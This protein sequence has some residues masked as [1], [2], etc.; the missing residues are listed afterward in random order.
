[1]Q[2]CEW[3]TQ[4]GN[5][6]DLSASFSRTVVTQEWYRMLLLNCHE[7]DYEARINFVAINPGGQHLSLSEVPYLYL[8][9]GLTWFW[10]LNTLL[11]WFMCYRY[12]YF[13]T[14]LQIILSLVP[15]FQAVFCS[16]VLLDYS[17]RSRTGIVPVFESWASV[18]MSCAR[19]GMILYGLFLVSYGYGITITDLSNNE[20]K[21]CCYLVAALVICQFLSHLW[22]EEFVVFLTLTGVYITALRKIVT[23]IT[24]N[25]NL[26]IQQ[27]QLVRSVPGLDI[28]K[29]SGWTKLFMFRRLQLNLC[30][31]VALN[32]F[33]F[34]WSIM[35][36]SDYP[37]RG[38]IVEQSA[39][40]YLC[41]AVGYIFAL[42]PFNPYLFRIARTEPSMPAPVAGSLPDP[43]RGPLMDHS[44]SDY[45]WQPG[46][47]PPSLDLALSRFVGVGEP[48]PLYIVS[49]PPSSIGGN[50]NIAF[51]TPFF[52]AQAYNVSLSAGEEG[53][54]KTDEK[55]QGVALN[56]LGPGVTTHSNINSV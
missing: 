40:I 56:I 17:K 36:F 27:L 39:L 46:M 21:Q 9:N 8:Y 26:M 13:N 14:K 50:P 48:E 31:F 43:L 11:W 10:F 41:Y 1:M 55:L 12:R 45:L 2:A 37:W 7:D 44:R 35:F 25:T 19:S 6:H 49:N 22:G 24:R 47:P 18:F 4:L 38:D 33:L 20:H 5:G 23:A 29:T 34:L 3:Q 32:V 30:I 15:L 28:T 54:S 53:A 52:E 51:A 42:R 16:L